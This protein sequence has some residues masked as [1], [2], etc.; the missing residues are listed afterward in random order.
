MILF[1]E[2]SPFVLVFKCN[3]WIIGVCFYRY[4]CYYRFYD[5]FYDGFYADWF[6]IYV[7]IANVTNVTNVANATVAYVIG[8]D[9]A[10]TVVVAVAA[11]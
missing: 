10:V 4:W 7:V 1:Q 2:F 11:T 3:F 5:G 9:L 8:N 6:W